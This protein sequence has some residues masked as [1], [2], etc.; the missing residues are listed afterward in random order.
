MCRQ[1]DIIS[2][3]YKSLKIIRISSLSISLDHISSTMHCL[4]ISSLVLLEPL[5]W[6]NWDIKVLVTIAISI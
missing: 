5:I 1:Q 3:F 4:T 2:V 6:V